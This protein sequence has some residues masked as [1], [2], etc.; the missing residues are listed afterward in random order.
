MGVCN[1][2]MCLQNSVE[3]QSSIA[4]IAQTLESDLDLGPNSSTYNLQLLEMIT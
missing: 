1:D 4:E 3:E 2:L